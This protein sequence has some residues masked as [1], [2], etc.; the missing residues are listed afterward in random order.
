MMT[1]KTIQMD[2]SWLSKLE[3][4]FEK[5]YMQNLRAF[6]LDEKQKGKLIYPP[7]KLI[8]NAFSQTS[9]DEVKV[10]IIGQDPYH[11][12]G[13]AHGLSFSVPEGVPPPPSLQNIF[14]EIHSDLGLP[15]L[16]KGCLLSWAKQGVLLLNATL[17]V[18]AGE[19]KSHHG[20]GWEQ[21]T[22]RVI[23]LLCEKEDPIVFLLWGKSALDKF[24]QIGTGSNRHLVLTAAHPS[25]L[26]A[27]AGFLGCRHFSQANAFL[28][29]RGKAP[30][31]WT[32][33]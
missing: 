17:S 22:D 29:N 8:F 3:T 12:P 6:L 19:A 23:Q 21:F 4:E 27:Y 14:K 1:E 24:Q 25:P 9:F 11:G 26:S 5:P 7:S 33:Q 10:V 30:I 13:Q 16:K 15:I 2:P 31:D 28:E 20:K 32:V 18:R